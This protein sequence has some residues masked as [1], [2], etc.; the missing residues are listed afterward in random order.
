MPVKVAPGSP[1]EQP[2]P[3]ETLRHALWS[4]AACPDGR[5]AALLIVTC[6]SPSRVRRPT[7]R[8]LLEFAVQQFAV[9]RVPSYHKCFPWSKNV[10]V[11]EGEAGH[12]PGYIEKQTNGSGIK[13]PIVT[14]LVWQVVFRHLPC[15]TGQ[16]GL[17]SRFLTCQLGSATWIPVNGDL[18]LLANGA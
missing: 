17:F 13:V 9:W 15:T 10:A 16:A 8:R 4:P 11:L 5:T 14:T 1:K 2:V 3:G 18:R 7:A 6:S 12:G